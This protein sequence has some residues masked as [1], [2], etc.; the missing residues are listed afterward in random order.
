MRTFYLVLQ[1]VKEVFDVKKKLL[2]FIFAAGI[3]SLPASLYSQIADGS[4]TTQ[5]EYLKSVEDTLGAL[6]F[7]MVNDSAEINRYAA[8]RKFIPLLTKVLRTEGSFEYPFSQL[9]QI[10]ILYPPD[11]SFRVFS[12]Q[13]YVD[14]ETYH[15][16]GA[17]QMNRGDLQLFPLIDRSADL[18]Y[19]EQ[20]VLTPERWYGVVY[21]N[22]KEFPTPDGMQYLLFGYDG[23]S[24]FEKRKIVDVL[25]FKDGK[26][27]LGAPVFIGGEK[28]ADSA[29]VQHRLVLQYSADASVR[30]NFDE[31]FDMITFDHLILSGGVY[32]G[33]G[34]V[35]VPDGSYSGYR[36]EDGKWKYVDKLFNQVQEEAPRDFPVLDSRKGK[37]IFGKER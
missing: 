10:S 9:R 23:F 1:L 20:L 29:K 4:A 11:S 24:F 25:S 21:Y 7:I 32:A 16:Y 2:V 8:C 28:A 14:E 26:P 19:P 12:W 5:E 36:L 27:I 3:L 34:P 17:I 30:L 37:N 13:L 33:Q 6:G 18:F 31:G 35:M 22:I 15:Y